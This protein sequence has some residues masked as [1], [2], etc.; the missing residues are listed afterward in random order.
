MITGIEYYYN[1]GSSENAMN[2]LPGIVNMYQ[3]SA[4]ENI[5]MKDKYVKVIFNENMYGN[6][7]VS[8]F[9]NRHADLKELVRM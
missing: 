8:Q 1:F 3:N 4:V 6:L 2:S 9:I 7:S 5:L